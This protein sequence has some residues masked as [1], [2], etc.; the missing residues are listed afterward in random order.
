MFRIDDAPS[1][2]VRVTRFKNGE[3]SA[4][5]ESNHS[6]R[7]MSQMFSGVFAISS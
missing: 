5:R 2:V 1:G 6:L 3:D 4:K 7:M